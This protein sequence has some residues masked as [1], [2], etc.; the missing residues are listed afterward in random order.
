M[1]LLP[2]GQQRTKSRGHA[3]NLWPAAAREPERSALGLR[4]PRTGEAARSPD[5]HEMLWLED[6]QQQVQ[7]ISTQAERSEELSLVCILTL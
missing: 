6:L 4:W 1:C 2:P 7:G 3:C 5:G